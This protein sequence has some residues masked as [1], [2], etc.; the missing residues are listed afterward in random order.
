MC[1]ELLNLRRPDDAR[2]VLSLG[3]ARW[4]GSEELAMLSSKIE[5]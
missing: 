5:P 2:Q 4:P 3:L 1:N